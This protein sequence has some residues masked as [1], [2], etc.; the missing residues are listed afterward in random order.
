MEY[1]IDVDEKCT[2]WFRNTLAIE[3]DSLEDAQGQVKRILEKGGMPD[4]IVDT[5]YLFDTCESMD[6][7]EN[8]GYGTVEM[9]DEN[10]DTIWSNGKY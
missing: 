4:L 7:S 2:I 5:Q 9:I 10:G 6:P 1:L 3:A 8:N